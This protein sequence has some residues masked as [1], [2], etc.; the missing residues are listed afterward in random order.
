MGSPRTQF[1]QRWLLGEAD[2]LKVGAVDPQQQLHAIGNGALIIADPRPVSRANFAQ[3]RARLRHHVGNAKRAADLDQLA[4]RDDNLAAFRQRVQRQQHGGGI[5]VDNDGRD[6]A[7]GHI[8]Q[9]R[10]EL[11]QVGVAFAALTGGKVELQVGIALRNFGHVPQ[12]L[13]A[14]RR[15][16]QIRVQD[17]AGSVDHRPQ[18]VRQRLLQPLLHNVR[19]IIE[20]GLELLL[21]QFACG[22]LGA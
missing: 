6:L 14:Q 11:V 20:S 18:R 15:A 16:A 5:I 22:D 9:L 21:V 8:Q 4:A 10:E 7:A 17:D 2:N 1:F 3:N 12:C 19:Q 13:C